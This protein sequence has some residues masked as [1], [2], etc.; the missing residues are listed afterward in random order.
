MAKI[1]SHVKPGVFEFAT[2]NNVWHK[3]ALVQFFKC[4]KAAYNHLSQWLGKDFPE[5][6]GGFSF[7]C[8][9]QFIVSKK[10][11]LARPKAMYVSLFEYIKN[12]DT[13]IDS[14][15]GHDNSC[16]ATEMMWHRIFGEPFY[17]QVR[18]AKALCGE[19]GADICKV[20]GCTGH[21]GIGS[22]PAGIGLAP[23]Q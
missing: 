13:T 11:I 16:Y 19:A 12:F 3:N 6:D 1:L 8:C 21:P 7:A 15:G 17:M 2:L 18:D 23:N 20:D 10:R 22:C 4:T 14:I 5:H 9:A